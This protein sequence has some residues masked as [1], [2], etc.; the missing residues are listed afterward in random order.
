MLNKITH[1]SNLLFIK[2]KFNYIERILSNE[3]I[4]SA[5][6]KENDLSTQS[7]KGN[8]LIKNTYLSK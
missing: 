1:K 4:L 7:Q 8:I 3:E 6:N 5:Y 2:M